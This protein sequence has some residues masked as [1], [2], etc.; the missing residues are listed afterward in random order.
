MTQ[1]EQQ[2][3]VALND[4][5]CKL[6]GLEDESGSH[7][8]ASILVSTCAA[9]LRCAPGWDWLDAEHSLSLLDD[10]WG[11]IWEN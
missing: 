8:A 7:A 3:E 1:A 6:A 2:G 4:A 10:I 11:L 9:P 5:R